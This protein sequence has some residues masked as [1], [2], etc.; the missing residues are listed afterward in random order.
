MS[1][2]PFKKRP[3]NAGSGL[4][5]RVLRLEVLLQQPLL[6]WKG[7]PCFSR[8]LSMAWVH[9][10]PICS[11]MKAL[12]SGRVMFLVVAIAFIGF[13]LLVEGLD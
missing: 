10:L 11:E 1:G 3:G 7:R 2:K 8:L 12:S 4:N 13:L 5:K 9:S 6:R